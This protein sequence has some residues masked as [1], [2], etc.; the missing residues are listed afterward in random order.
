VYMCLFSHDQA[1]SNKITHRCFSLA[2]WMCK[3][4]IDRMSMI[5]EG[6][7][8]RVSSHTRVVKLQVQ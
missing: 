2:G 3:K 6:W 7:Q 1:S 5:A 8:F 4:C